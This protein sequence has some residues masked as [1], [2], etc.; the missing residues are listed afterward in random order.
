MNK[1][2][3]TY[4]LDGCGRCSLGGTPDCKVHSWQDELQLLRKIMLDCGLTEVS[5]WGVPCYMVGKSNVVL[6]GALKDCATLGFIKGVLLDNKSGLLEKQ[7]ENSNVGRII[8]FTS[9]DQI[10]KNESKIK[11]LVFQAV[12]IEKKG[13]KVEKKKVK[14]PIP[15]ELQTEFEKSPA[16]KS[17]FYALTSGRQ[18]GY[19]IHF[20]QPKQSATKVSRIEKCKGKILNG[21]GLHDHYKHC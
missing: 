3:E 10:T 6:I 17:A 20:N 11:E 7:G 13:L 9:T 8:R 18:R 16:L 5:K 2:V 4:F 15:E 21:V 19:L 12:E 1:N 14:E